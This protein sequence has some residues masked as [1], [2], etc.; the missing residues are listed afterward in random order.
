MVAPEDLLKESRNADAAVGLVSAKGGKAAD[1]QV[2]DGA[3]WWDAA[4]D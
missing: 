2:A 3:W 1:G 4:E